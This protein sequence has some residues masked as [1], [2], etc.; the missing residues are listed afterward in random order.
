MGNNGNVK[1]HVF[2][3]EDNKDIEKLIVYTKQLDSLV[4]KKYGEIL[5]QRVC[6]CVQ[7]LL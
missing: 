3:Q 6:T 7:H 1:W 5:F 2:A 4:M